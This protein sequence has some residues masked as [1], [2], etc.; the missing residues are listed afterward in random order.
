M[1]ILTTSQPLRPT[2]GS[3]VRIPAVGRS[4]RPAV[5]MVVR[6][7]IRQSR[8]PSGVAVRRRMCVQTWG[9]PDASDGRLSDAIFQGD[10]QNDNPAHS[11]SSLTTLKVSSD[12][13]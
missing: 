8:P 7:A 6:Y 4:G 3:T 12:V 13:T 10:V 1:A 2:A 9:H 5:G 11:L